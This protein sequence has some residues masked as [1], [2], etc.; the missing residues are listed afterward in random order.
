MLRNIGNFLRSPLSPSRQAAQF[1]E[2]KTLINM[3]SQNLNAFIQM[4]NDDIS[5]IHFFY[6]LLSHVNIIFQENQKK[7]PLSNEET[8]NIISNFISVCAEFGCYILND[9]KHDSE[10][11]FSTMIFISSLLEGYLPNSEQF[12]P[13]FCEMVK[14]IKKNP[15]FLTKCQTFLFLLFKSADF[16]TKFLVSDGLSI[17]FSLI[18]EKNDESLINCEKIKSVYEILLQLTFKTAPIEIYSKIPFTKI[19]NFKVFLDFITNVINSK[20]QNEFPNEFINEFLFYAC[21]FMTYYLISFSNSCSTLIEL[22]YSFDGFKTLNK[23]FK[24]SCPQVAH[25]CYE[26][27]LIE[28]G[29]DKYVLM[30]IVDLYQN[31]LTDSS[32]RSSLISLLTIQTKNINETYEKLTL[33][34][35]VSSYLKRP[36]FLNKKGLEELAQVIQTFLEQKMINISVL[37]NSILF[38]IS[39]PE[40]EEIPVDSFLNILIFSYHSKDLTVNMLLQEKF[41]QNFLFEQSPEDLASYFSHHKIILELIYF[42]YISSDADEYRFPILQNLLSTSNFISD[43]PDFNQFL[44]NLLEQQFSSKICKLLLSFIQYDHIFELL[45]KEMKKKMEYYNY[46]LES[47]GFDHLNEYINPNEQQNSRSENKISYLLIMNLIGSL[48]FFTEQPEVDEWINQQP[49]DSP[50]FDF[51]NDFLSKLAFGPETEHEY[52]LLHVPS[53][54]PFCTGFDQRLAY[55]LYLAGKYGIPACLKRGISINN[56]PHISLIANR[57]ITSN[58]AK[59]LFKLNP[60]KISEFV[61]VEQPQFSLY[62]IIPFSNPVFLTFEQNF[63]SLSFWFNLPIKINEKFL[64]LTIHSFLTIEINQDTLLFTTA[65]EKTSL[66]T[67]C[68]IWHNLIVIFHSKRNIAY[69]CEIILDFTTRLSLKIDIQST[70][71]SVTFGDRNNLI[72]VPIQLAKS[73]ILSET[74][75][76]EENIS[77]I[78]KQGPNDTSAKIGCTSKSK[79]VF[80]VHYLGFASYYNSSIDSENLFFRLE[81]IDFIDEFKSLFMVLLNLKSLRNYNFHLFWHRMII[82]MKRKKSLV[83]SHLDY[84]ILNPK[85]K[86]KISKALNIFLSDPEIYFVFD[87][88]SIINLL[89]QISSTSSLDWMILEKF[90]LS[91]SLFSILRCGINLDI[92]LSL[93]P[94][95]NKLFKASHTVIKLKNILNTIVSFGDFTFDKTSF[96]DLIKNP[97]KESLVQNKLFLSFVES[98]KM[99]SEEVLQLNQLL[100]IIILYLD[101]RIFPFFD[102]LAFYSHRNQKYIRDTKNMILNYVFNYF[103]CEKQVWKY[104]FSILSGNVTQS[105]FYRAFQVKRPSFLPVII[106]MLSKLAS[107]CAHDIINSH[108]EDQSNK[109]LFSKIVSIIL[110][111]DESITAIIS[112]SSLVYYFNLAQL[113]MMPNSFLITN[114]GER[115]TQNWVNFSH[116]N[117]PSKNEIK[118]IYEKVTHSKIFPPHFPDTINYEPLSILSISSIYSSSNNINFPDNHTNCLKLFS[119]VRESNLI[120]LLICILFASDSFEKNFTELINGTAMMYLEYWKLLTQQIIFDVLTILS[121]KPPSFTYFKWCFP[122][123]HKCITIGLFKKCYLKL[124]ELIFILIKRGDILNNVFLED[125][126]LKM[127]RDFLLLSFRYISDETEHEMHFK[128]LLKNKNFIFSPN[129]FYDN[130]FCSLWLHANRLYHDEYPSRIECMSLFMKLIDN[131]LVSS[132]D[133]SNMEEE[134]NNFCRKQLFDNSDIESKQTKMN[135]IIDNRI[136]MYTEVLKRELYTRI[137]RAINYSIEENLHF[138]QINLR[139]RKTEKVM[140]KF[141]KLGITQFLRQKNHAIKSYHLSPLSY[142]IYQ[143]R[144]LS[145]SPFSIRSPQSGSKINNSY[146]TID[147]IKSKQAIPIIE[148]YGKLNCAPEWFFFNS[149]IHCDDNLNS[150][151]DEAMINVTNKKDNQIE[152]A[153]SSPFDYSDIIEQGDAPLLQ[154]FKQT[155]FEFG[156]YYHH[157]DVSFFYYIHPLPSV[158]FVTENALLLIVLAKGSLELISHPN[159]PIAFLPL[160]ESIALGEFSQASLFCGHI[161]IISK[162]DQILKIQ[163]H[164]YIHKNYGVLISTL[165]D[166]DL[167]LIFANQNDKSKVIKHINKKLQKKTFPPSHLL[168]SINSISEATLLWHNNVISNFDYLLLLNSYGGRSFSDLSQYPVVPWI[169]NPANNRELRNLSLPMGQLSETR[170]HHFDLTYELST[171]VKYYYGFHYSLPGVVFWLLMRTPPFTFFQWDLNEG[172]DNSQRLFVSVSDAYNSAAI[173]NQSDLKELIPAMYQTPEVLTNISNLSLNVSDNVQLPEWAKSSPYFY[174][175]MQKKILNESQETQKWIDL[176]FGYKQTGEAARESKNLFLPSSY[177][178]SSYEELEMDEESYNSQ[179]LNFGQCPNQLF[180]KSHPFKLTRKIKDEVICETQITI[181]LINP[182]F[183]TNFLVAPIHK[184]STTFVALPETAVVYPLKCSM[185]TFFINFNQEHES[186]SMIEI[187]TMKTVLTTY[188]FDFAFIRHVDVSEDGFFIVVSFFFGRVDV[189]LVDFDELNGWPK[190]IQKFGSFSRRSTCKM[191]ALLPQEYICA[192][193]YEDLKII[194]WNFSTETIHRV[195]N[196]EF[197]PIQIMF[198]S[199][200][201]ELYVIYSNS[202]EKYS[203][204]G[205][206]LHYYDIFESNISSSII[207]GLDFMFDKRLLILGHKNGKLTI[208]HINSESYEFEVMFHSDVHKYAIS[209]ILGMPNLMKIVTVDDRGIS[210][211]TDFSSMLEDSSVVVRCSFCDSPQTTICKICQLPI[212]GGCKKNGQNVCPQCQIK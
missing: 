109:R 201:A 55:N 125:R 54:L 185:S 172:W 111:L 123:I 37:L 113:G 153:F 23:I 115:I 129:V 151:H 212:C 165:G 187:S 128:L 135:L 182:L 152:N 177:I 180:T 22:F 193:V 131:N 73:V 36:P 27:L 105:K 147:F 119:F 65:K 198:D 203:I 70:P 139:Q 134:W 150:S 202:V 122:Q 137:Y 121:L 136:K 2:E 48:S 140:F 181:N 143:S 104:A 15:L 79:F 68:C 106:D 107:H 101:N 184:N 3:F 4:E 188:S 120:D 14:V 6:D 91:R 78:S 67:P 38:I 169:S 87:Q 12:F 96:G 35:P 71:S 29:I 110:S 132:Y 89:G 138:Y 206:K 59:E 103:S 1:P 155:F 166:S 85:L 33:V 16:F 174:V 9:E 13:L 10:L 162:L 5:K 80:D 175:E 83:Q 81:K 24:L 164:H 90:G 207:F 57:F 100:D 192:S 102:L 76:S 114:N 196:L 62:E 154:L 31:E 75:F 168:F 26:I 209:S 64:F 186:L 25:E 92:Q 45:I 60:L 7:D 148:K 74:V 126:L 183:L 58:V 163:D 194:I 40:D 95:F 197:L 17:S 145:P 88:D 61:N 127:Y 8:K 39:F 47:N 108:E 84:F 191:S 97:L 116:I 94:I 56:I 210:Y 98:A 159:N 51:S 200:N 46:F 112:Q 171:P 32:L 205:N 30:S 11:F 157:F 28:S 142:P 77:H 43:L 124:M 53:L 146:F 195:L 158:L 156:E 178:N 86:T 176:I 167:L 141:T 173:T 130:K 179:V 18:F 208:L 42:I 72:P 199:F 118:N 41:L 34:A 63:S 161:V 170:A 133:P 117:S 144:L 20:D 211:L 52:K 50:L 99:F 204:N 19:T 149:N 49:K 189:F 44:S 93:I 82:A 69:K 66:S 190:N 160:T 21:K